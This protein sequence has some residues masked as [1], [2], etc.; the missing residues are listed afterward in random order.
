MAI[1]SC[2][3]SVIVLGI[4]RWAATVIG[5]PGLGL[6]RK[7]DRRPAILVWRAP[8]ENQAA[9]RPD[10]IVMPVL[11]AIPLVHVDVVNAVAG[12]EAKDLVRR[13]VLRPPARTVGV[14]PAGRVGERAFD[15]EIELVGEVVAWAR[16]AG[17]DAPHVAA[18]EHPAAL[19]IQGET[20]GSRLDMAIAVVDR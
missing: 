2:R 18:V 6:E 8:L 1:P 4:R 11:I 14:E 19:V 15:V 13:V 16:K 12:S 10:P 20:A 17:R 7:E 3:S 9:I 5:L